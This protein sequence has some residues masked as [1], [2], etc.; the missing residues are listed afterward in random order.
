[1]AP[2]QGERLAVLETKIEFIETAVKR[3]DTK[4]EEV[5]AAVSNLAAAVNVTAAAEAT[6]EAASRFTRF[7]DIGVR[8]AALVLSIVNFMIL[9]GVAI[10]T[11]VR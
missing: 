4:F 6:K 10:A 11:Q 2:T 9:V 5:L 3:H 7:V 8:T 1:M